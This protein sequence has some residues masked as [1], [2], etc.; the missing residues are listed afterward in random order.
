MDRT[1]KTG[2]SNA[3]ILCLVFSA[4][5]AWGGAFWWFNTWLVPSPYPYSA[6]LTALFV[7]IIIPAIVTG[8]TGF[9]RF[10]VLATGLYLGIYVLHYPFM[11]LDPL[12][13]LGLAIGVPLVLTFSFFGAVI[14]EIIRK[15]TDYMLN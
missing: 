5:L 4:G 3:L 14:G 10:F 6:T 7:W 15:L 13:P 2:P 12:L 8:Y 9:I 11:P 1:Q